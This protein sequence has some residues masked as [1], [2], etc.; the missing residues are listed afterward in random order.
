VLLLEVL[1]V[2]AHTKMFAG[3][4]AVPILPARSTSV[5]GGVVPVTVAPSALSVAEEAHGVAASDVLYVSG[6]YSNEPSSK[7]APVSFP[8]NP[9]IGFGLFW[10]AQSRPAGSPHVMSPIVV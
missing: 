10:S 3:A 5:N 7:A 1:I 2:V 8:P 9:L 6:K 4:D